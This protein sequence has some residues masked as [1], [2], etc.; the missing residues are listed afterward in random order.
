M[1]IAF[2]GGVVIASIR[3]PGWR[4]KEKEGYEKKNKETLK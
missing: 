3:C 1:G 2:M 4:N